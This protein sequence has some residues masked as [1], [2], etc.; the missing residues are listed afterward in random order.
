MNR[1]GLYVLIAVLVVA[2]AGLGYA[3]Q[4]ER[5]KTSGIHI[6]TDDNGISIEHKD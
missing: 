3:Y 5:D 4:R 2:V 1:S 6:E